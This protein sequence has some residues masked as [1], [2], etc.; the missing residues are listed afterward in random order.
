MDKNFKHGYFA[1]D[2]DLQDPDYDLRQ[3]L[4]SFRRDP[5]TSRSQQGYLQ[6]LRDESDRR[7]ALW[8]YEKSNKQ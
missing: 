7:D 2:K 6:R 1:A 3:A 4:A 5:A 8:A